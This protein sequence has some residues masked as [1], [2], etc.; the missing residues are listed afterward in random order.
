MV[1]TND[2]LKK[3]LYEFQLANGANLVN[4]DN[5]EKTIEQGYNSNPD[6]YSIVNYL[7]TLYVKAQKK[8]YRKKGDK[9]EEITDPE[10]VA[11]VN[12]P[13]KTETL[14][15]FEKMRYS[16]YLVTGNS[17]VYAPRLQNGNNVGRLIPGVGRQVMPSQYTEI[18]TGGWNEPVKGYI[19]NYNFTATPLP[20]DSVIHIKMPNLRY[21]N[22][23]NFYGMSP[24]RVASHII[25]AQ[26][27]GYEAMASTLKRGFPS[28]ILTKDDEKDGE[29]EALNR[30]NLFKKIWKRFYG[31]A[32][33]SGEPIITAGKMNWIPMGFSNFRDLQII[34]SSQHG[35]RLLCNLY[36]LPSIVLN[37][38]QG[39]TF[40]N[41]NEVKK[42][43]YD[44]R[45][46]PDAE[47]F[48]EV[49]NIFI[50]K[51]YGI[52]VFTDFSTIPELQQDKKATIEVIRSAQEA[53]ALYSAE[54]IRKRIDDD[55][56]EDDIMK[57]R[58]MNMG[59]IPASQV[60][61]PNVEETLKNLGIEH[62]LK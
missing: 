7:S 18:A 37:D 2:E 8:P 14:R 29:T 61:E 19:I 39:T 55:T 49:D 36:G 56:P 3:L 51:N 52:E 54:E 22:G 40:N 10:I 4:F 44:A 26:N 48:D 47:L 12:R 16:F 33:N 46:I 27:S 17:F 25:Q 42:R 35:L 30:S 62:Y 45:I 24:I 38:I 60:I 11:L 50:W 6:V 21:L 59:K 28:G 32:K 23:D 9:Y 15:Q 34:E 5:L 57:V 20:V 43:V 53:G 13:N 1:K 31:K 58:F 41:Q